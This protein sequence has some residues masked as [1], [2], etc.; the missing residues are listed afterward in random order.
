MK[1]ITTVCDAYVTEYSRLGP[2]ELAQLENASVL[3][4]A[5]H[6][7]TKSGWT[8][9]G[10]ATITVELVNQDTMVTNKVEALRGQL[11]ELRAKA[12]LEASLI[13]DQIQQ[14]LAITYTPE[15]AA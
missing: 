6:D 14:L 3:A 11:A 13:E 7:M 1:T 2:V 9:V 12:H 5:T 10:T 15:V 4:Y 8:K